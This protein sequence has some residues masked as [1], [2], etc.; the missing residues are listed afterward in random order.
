MR[1]PFVAA[2]VLLVVGSS[3]SVVVAKERP[4][5]PPGTVTCSYVEA[6][7]PGPADNYLSATVRGFEVALFKRVGDR[8][9]VSGALGDELSCGTQPTVSNIDRIEVHADRDSLGAVA[10]VDALLGGATP[11]S[12]GTGE[13]ELSLDQPNGFPAVW[14]TAGV[15][16]MTAGTTAD[17]G[18]GINID[19]GEAVPDIDVSASGHGVVL[20]G[21]DGADA[22]SG[23]GGP[24]FAGPLTGFSGIS[25]GAG[26]DQVIGGAA[27]DDIEAGPGDDAVAAGT[28]ADFV[29]DGRGRDSVDAGPGADALYSQHSNK[30][31]LLCGGGSDRVAINRPDRIHHCETVERHRVSGFTFQYK[32]PP[33][34]GL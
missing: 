1:A 5:P 15:D 7:L 27:K 9:A 8:I 6:G 24:G 26:D 30:D 31:R 23:A 20:S 25:G 13:I 10:T 19:A 32:L 4:F 34:L 16:R 3:A 22:L 33:F 14:G 2:A 11:E 18:A 21:F 17:G 28:G 29:S 12:D